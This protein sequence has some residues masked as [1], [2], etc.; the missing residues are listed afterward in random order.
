[1][2]SLVPYPAGTT[3]LLHP[4]QAAAQGRQCG[5]PRGDERHLALRARRG[6]PTYPL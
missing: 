2:A 6:Q 3:A 5:A 1:M 4:A